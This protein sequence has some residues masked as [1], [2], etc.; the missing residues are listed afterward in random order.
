MDSFYDSVDSVWCAIMAAL[1]TPSMSWIASICSITRF[2]VGALTIK[3]NFPQASC[4]MRSTPS[5][6][7]THKLNGDHRFLF[8]MDDDTDNVFLILPRGNLHSIF[9]FT[10]SS[11][12]CRHRQNCNRIR[13]ANADAFATTRCSECCQ[14]QEWVIERSWES[15]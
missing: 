13:R 14:F 15:E 11:L 7:S 10:A 4:V 12:Y 5:R 2:A 3:T 6:P 8:H 1:N 9:H